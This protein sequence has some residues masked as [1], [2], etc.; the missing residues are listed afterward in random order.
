MF[1]EHA[2]KDSRN[3]YTGSDPCLHAMTAQRKWLWDFSLPMIRDAGFGK[4]MIMGRENLG[5]TVTAA[6]DQAIT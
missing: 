3:K 6:N 4:L 1:T 2:G 5:S